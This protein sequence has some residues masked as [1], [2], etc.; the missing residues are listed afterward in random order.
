MVMNLLTTKPQKMDDH[1]IKG[2]ISD[3]LNRKNEIS[4]DTPETSVKFELNF[5]KDSMR[6]FEDQLKV[7]DSVVS[8]EVKRLIQSE[9]YLDFERLINTKIELMRT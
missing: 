3:I 2:I 8:K 4:D 7:N 6:V 5:I 9:S 1:K